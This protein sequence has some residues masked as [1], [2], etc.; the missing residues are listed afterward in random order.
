[1]PGD[2][3]HAAKHRRDGA[4]IWRHVAGLLIGYMRLLIG[5]TSLATEGLPVPVGELLPESACIPLFA[6][7][8]SSKHKPTR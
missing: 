6:G 1:M 2:V 3:T 4:T 5:Y 8:F 7:I